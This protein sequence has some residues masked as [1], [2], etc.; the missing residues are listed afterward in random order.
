L[1]TFPAGIPFT[2]W[3]QYTGLKGQLLGASGA[4]AG[5]LFFIIAFFLGSPWAA[6]VALLSI[7]CLW[8]FLWGAMAVVLGLQ[9]S[10]VPAVLLVCAVGLA[11]KPTVHVFLGFSS[12]LGSKARRTG[13]MLEA[14]A[15][16]V[17][18]SHV[19][20]VLAALMLALAPFDF[21]V[22][23]VLFIYLFIFSF[24]ELPNIG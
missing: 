10:A 13:A 8:L 14:V 24:F 4:A 6:L 9:L 1:P 18:H 7:G 22:R 21:I 12:A 23:L 5:A 3:E 11:G 17:F 2:F 16:S 20:V 19:A 15:P